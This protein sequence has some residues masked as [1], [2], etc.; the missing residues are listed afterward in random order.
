MVVIV[1]LAGLSVL[2]PVLV[3]QPVAATRL[4]MLLHRDRFTHTHLTY[5]GLHLNPHGYTNVNVAAV[6]TGLKRSFIIISLCVCVC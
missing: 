5:T 4:L 3:W 2:S 1:G 6:K